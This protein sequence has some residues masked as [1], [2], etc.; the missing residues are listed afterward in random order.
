MATLDR[1][2]GENAYVASD[3]FTV[4]DIPVG[5]AAYRWFEMPIEREDYPNLKRWYDTLAQRPGFIKHI[6]IG[7]S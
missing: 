7:L 5:I 4:G 6:A 1:Y 3:N 2:V